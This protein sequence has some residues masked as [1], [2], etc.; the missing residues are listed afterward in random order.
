MMPRAEMKKG[1]STTMR[2]FN[3]LTIALMPIAIVINI[4]LGFIVS[5]VG[6]PFLYG[7]SIGTLLVGVLAGPLAGGLTGL[8]SNIVWSLLF[9][10]RVI[11]W[12]APVAFLIGVL[13]G[14]FGA[15]AWL[16]RWYLAIV[17]GL[18]T[19]LVGAI[20][21]APIAAY[22]FGGVTGAGTDLL[23]ATFLQATNDILSANFLQGLV[24]EFV[25]KP[26]SY[27]IVFFILSGLPRRLLVRFPQG[28]KS[29]EPRRTPLIGRI[30]K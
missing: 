15:R 28:E 13:A 7:D 20:V 30:E 11:I 26:L 1:E 12:F 19:G 21:S 6:I 23:V 4:V 27:L 24:T 5:R 22:L 16:R 18:I 2:S 17:A 9:A 14:I 10:D 8:L 3:T 25:D 29:A